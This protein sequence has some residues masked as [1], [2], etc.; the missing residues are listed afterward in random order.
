[1]NNTL[2][3]SEN[4]EKLNDNNI[5]PKISFYYQHYNDKDKENDSLNDVNDYFDK[6]NIVFDKFIEIK[7]KENTNEGKLLQRKNKDKKKL[8]IYLDKNKETSFNQIVHYK[9]EE[10]PR[11]NS[12]TKKKCGRK[13]FRPNKYNKEHNKYSDDNIIRRCKHL[14]LKNVLQFINY[15]IKKEYNGNI[16]KGILKKELHII[17]QSQKTDATINFNKNFLNKTLKEIFSTKI[18]TRYTNFP[19][20]HN[21]I[22][23]DILLNEKDQNKKIYFN[24]LFN[25]NFIQCL[26]HFRG[27]NPI[28]ELEGTKCF[29]DIKNELLK[30]YIEDGEKYIDTLEYYLNNYEEITI[31]KKARKSRKQQTQIH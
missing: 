18:S 30:K 17:N 16:G 11:K 3:E 22:I 5:F 13:R 24:N 19:P 4:I 21:K 29:S 1:M 15:Q 25:I 10:N 20:N 6:E 31:N 2:F 26:G 7:T 12:L 23:I 14:V 27:K 8:Y 9:F 28:R